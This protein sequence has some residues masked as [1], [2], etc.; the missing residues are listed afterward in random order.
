ML[1]LVLAAGTIL[2]QKQKIFSYKMLQ[3]GFMKLKGKVDTIKV[4]QMTAYEGQRLI[5]DNINTGHL[6][7][8]KIGIKKQQT[9]QWS[10]AL[11]QESST[12]CM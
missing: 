3:V 11:E 5:Q 10:K 12:R 7:Q 1:T 4:I 9:G 2:R 8:D 6:Y